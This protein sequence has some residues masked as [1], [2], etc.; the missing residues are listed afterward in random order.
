[1]PKEPS[2][3]E[4]EAER[5]EILRAVLAGS[6]EEAWPR[7]RQLLIES[8]SILPDK[9]VLTIWEGPSRG[10]LLPLPFEALRD[11]IHQFR[12]AATNHLVSALS[13]SH[14]LVVGYA[15]HALSEIDP[16][17]FST[18]ASSVAGRTERIHTIYGSFGWEGS[19]AD[20]A[21][22]LRDDA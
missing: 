2:I 1:M 21:I 16:D 11:F 13:D 17:R 4:L 18:Y 12:N 6:S 9:G 3:T 14:P 10:V 15:L 8:P 22:R 7:V 5:R 20:Y 19:L